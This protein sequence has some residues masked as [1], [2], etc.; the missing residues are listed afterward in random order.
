MN[1]NSHDVEITGLLNV[2][3]RINLK[4]GGESGL[5]ISKS[6]LGGLKVTILFEKK[7]SSDK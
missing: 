2:H 4:L 5:V 1:S 6:E 7:G 3:K